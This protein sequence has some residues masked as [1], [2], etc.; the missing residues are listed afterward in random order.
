MPTEDQSVSAVVKPLASDATEERVLIT[1]AFG[2][3]GARIA[4]ILIGEGVTVVGFDIAPPGDR[5][6]L[7]LDGDQLAAITVVSGDLTKIEDLASAV[8]EHGITRIIHLAALQVPQ[9]QANPPLGAAVNVVGTANVFA[10]AKQR[11][12]RI[13]NVV[14]ASSIAAFD[15]AD[16]AAAP[17]AEDAIGLP[18]THYG[19]HKQANEGTARVYWQQDGVRS[20]GLRPFVVYGVGR[21]QGLTSQ[22]TMAM[23]AAAREQPYHI[24][25]GGSLQMEYA[26]D[27]AHAFVAASRTRHDGARVFNTGGDTVVQVGDIVA[28]IERAAPTAAG[29]ITFDD[30]P[31]PFPTDFGPSALVDVLGP[32]PRTSLE[33]GVH[34][35]VEDFRRL[36]KKGLLAHK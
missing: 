34:E 17:I 22:A 11:Q 3:L 6:R 25:F 8:D 23:L 27:V 12:P 19:V 16:S 14:Y 9:C 10:V 21:D 32:V 7:I 18:T 13:V 15:T 31:L 20:I 29:T 26:E 1:G 30:T 24:G 36:L 5:A 33:K 35:T 2:L 4:R 28:A